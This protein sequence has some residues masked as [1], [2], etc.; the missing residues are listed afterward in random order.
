M[1]VVGPR[2]RLAGR[3]RP[4]CHGGTTRCPSEFVILTALMDQRLVAFALALVV[5]GGPLASDVCGAV[6]AEHTGHHRTSTMAPSHH[7]HSEPA[8][9]QHSHHHSETAAPV[10]RGVRFTPRPHVCSALDAVVTESRELRRAAADSAVVTT[11]S[12][13]TSL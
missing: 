5:I 2:H 11:V 9:A 10:T 13:A 3:S 6:C 8:A 4:L 1:A 7:H 12:L